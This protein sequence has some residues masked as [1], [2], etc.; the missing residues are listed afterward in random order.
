MSFCN[1]AAG[2][3]GEVAAEFCFPRAKPNRETFRVESSSNGE[4]C[5]CDCSSLL[6][7]GLNDPM[8]PEETF[9]CGGGRV[10]AAS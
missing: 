5:R 1:D 10:A 9:D 8:Y 2:G 4:Y 7:K 3:K 6:S